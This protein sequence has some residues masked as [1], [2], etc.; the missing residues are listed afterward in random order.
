MAIFP[1]YTALAAIVGLRTDF[2]C[3]FQNIF[4]SHNIEDNCFNHEAANSGYGHDGSSSRN[5]D[6]L[7][8]KLLCKTRE[9]E[10]VKANTNE[11]I[12][13]NSESM[14]QM[15]QLLGVACQERD[16]ARDQLQKLTT[17]LMEHMIKGKTLPQQGKLVQAISEAGPLLQTL[18]VRGPLPRW[19][20]P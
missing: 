17:M 10:A 14:K 13:R 1:G 3:F 16:E 5:I 11:E 18:M 20:N 15:L 8:Q 12:K 9:L 7:K 6:E 19:R 4:S 2:L